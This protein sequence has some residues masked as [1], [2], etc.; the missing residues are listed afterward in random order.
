[1]IAGRSHDAAPLQFRLNALARHQPGAV[2]GVL[3]YW[4]ATPSGESDFDVKS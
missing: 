2:I 1:L 4:L 3:E